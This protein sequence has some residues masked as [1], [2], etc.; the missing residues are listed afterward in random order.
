MSQQAQIGIESFQQRV[1]IMSTALEPVPG[2][3]YGHLDQG[4]LFT[5]VDVDG[6]SDMAELQHFDGDIEEVE[7]A[8]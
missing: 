1:E 8:A 3:G 4:Q 5:A 7:L 2:H 6:D